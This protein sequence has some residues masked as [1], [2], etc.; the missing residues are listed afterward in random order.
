LHAIAFRIRTR[1][2]AFGFGFGLPA[3]PKTA[4]MPCRR[5]TFNPARAKDEPRDR[6]RSWCMASRN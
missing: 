6:V 3:D 4:G 1:Y 5:E 2:S